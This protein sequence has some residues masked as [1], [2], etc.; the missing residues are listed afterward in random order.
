MDLSQL[1]QISF[2]PKVGKSEVKIAVIVIGANTIK[3]DT[4]FVIGAV[5][6]QSCQT[7]QL[8]NSISPS[9]VKVTEG[10]KIVVIQ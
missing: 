1:N 10:N 4:S 7:F 6:C 5:M 2:K 3:F 8:P 9:N